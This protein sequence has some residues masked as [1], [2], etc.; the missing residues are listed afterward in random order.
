[1]REHN[2]VTPGTIGPVHVYR[3]PNRDCL[4][5]EP[6]MNE[7]EDVVL[8][9]DDPLVPVEVQDHGRRFKSPARFVVPVGEG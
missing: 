2:K 5:M 4:C 3:I 9:I 7:H 6:G 8:A 1:M